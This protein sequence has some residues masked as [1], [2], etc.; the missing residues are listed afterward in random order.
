MRAL[1]LVFLTLLTGC[2][3][4]DF[5]FATAKT[6]GGAGASGQAGA[7]GAAGTAGAGGQA[8]EAADGGEAGQGGAGGQSNPCGPLMIPH[9]AYCV[10]TRPALHADGSQGGAV[11]WQEALTICEARGARLCTEE[12][13]E[14]ACPDGQ[15][16][17][18]TPANADFCGGPAST[19]E[20][21]GSAA[22]SGGRCLSPCCN[23]VNYP[24]QCSA[25][26]EQ[27]QGYRCCKDLPT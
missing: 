9:G 16:S 10:D 2:G 24:C 5:L 11:S 23:T 21:S 20:W 26:A 1:F 15:V 17:L 25:P 3:G 22:C 12:E 19:W 14:D 4:S 8:G 7:A 13:R 27:L 18:N 6:D